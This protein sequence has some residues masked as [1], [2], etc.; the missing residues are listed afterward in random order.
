MTSRLSKI[1]HFATLHQRPPSVGATQLLYV[2]R[3]WRVCHLTQIDSDKGTLEWAE[4]QTPRQSTSQ[5]VSGIVVDDDG[6]VDAV[7]VPLADRSRLERRMRLAERRSHDAAASRSA[8]T[9][10]LI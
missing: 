10:S 2:E 7:I 4:S 1:S 9:A 8:R 3:Q 6:F 5:F